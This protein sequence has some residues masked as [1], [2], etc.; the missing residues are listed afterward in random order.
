[1]YGVFLAML[2]TDLIEKTARRAL[3][4]SI[5][6]FVA[7]NLIYGAKGNIDNAGHIG[8][9]I[10]GIIIG[11]CFIPSLKKPD[12]K[13][14]NY[15]IIG[16][17]TVLT[18]IVCSFVYRSIPNDLGSYEKK[19]K[20]FS[21]MESMA[22]EVYSL[23][24]NTPK[25]KLLYEIKDRGIYY[26]NED[27]KIIEE[28]EKLQLPEGVHTQADKLKQYCKLRI[29][30]YELLYKT[31]NEDSNQYQGQIEDYNKQI[32]GVIDELKKSK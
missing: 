6:I 13:P 24:K 18:I 23:P 26:W 22:L 30:S 2:T 21:S 3:L 1:M 4:T 25:S 19:M 10:G 11:Y 7:Y 8:G 5:G 31:V 28:V 27:L 12:D 15:S 16:L 14:L 32:Q 29:K 17:L 20:Q 9:L